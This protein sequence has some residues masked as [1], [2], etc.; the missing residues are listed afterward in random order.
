M[1][2]LPQASQPT[3]SQ[4]NTSPAS[5]TNN[6]STGAKAPGG[7]NSSGTIKTPTPP[8]KLASLTSRQT[9]W[10]MLFYGKHG[11]GK[12]LLA[13]TAADYEPF[14]DVFIVAAEKGEMTLDTTDRIKHK[15]N[16]FPVPINTIGELEQVKQWLI[17]HCLRRDQNNEAEL[18][19]LELMVGLDNPGPAKRFKT[20][21]IDT[22]TEL[23]AF[24]IY[25]VKGMGVDTK[26]DAALK[27]SDWDDFNDILERMKLIMRAYRDLPMNVIFLAQELYNQNE[28][29]KWIFAPQLQGKMSTQIQ[30]FVDVVGY[31][32]KAEIQEEE[33]KSLE[34]RRLFLQ[35]SSRFDAKCRVASFKKNW[36]DNPTIP[37][38]MNEFG[39]GTDGQGA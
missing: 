38:L 7:T 26:L 13:A 34:V 11:I 16:L 4:N 23:Q 32:T 21:I 6:N 24:S 2:Q 5:P 35:P 37:M 19:R 1:A 27:K 20:V 8:F 28:T 36:L 17:A 25:K 9:W 10:K 15:A 30:G 39:V 3:K 12:S 29:K 14:Q 22:V 18:K 33:G 31:L